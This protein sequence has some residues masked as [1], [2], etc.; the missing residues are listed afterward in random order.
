VDKEKEKGIFPYII[1]TNSAGVSEI[2]IQNNNT[3]EEQHNRI[4]DLWL[5]PVIGE[6]NE[7]IIEDLYKEN[8]C[9]A[10]IK[11]KKQIV[12]EGQ[13]IIEFTKKEQP[14][15]IESCF[16]ILKVSAHPDWKAT[17]KGKS[18]EEIKIYGV[19]PNFMGINLDDI[20]E[21]E[22]VVEFSFKVNKTREILLLLLV[23]TMLSLFI[24]CHPKGMFLYQILEDRWGKE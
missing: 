7:K 20:E 16:L 5:R 11:K 12:G 24:I 14:P 6:N 23:L 3:K 9:G 13:Y 10:V 18:K 22:Y 17:I 8:V 21:G 15:G 2:F 19:S 1:T 4:Q